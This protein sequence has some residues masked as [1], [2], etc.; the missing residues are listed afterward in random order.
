MVRGMIVTGLEKWVGLGKVK[1]SGKD[2]I[3]DPSW[4]YKEFGWKY[5]D[6]KQRKRRSKKP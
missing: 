2:D 4:I 3:E 1:Y 6:R 5:D